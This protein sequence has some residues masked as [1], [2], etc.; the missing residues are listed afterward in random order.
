MSN[1]KHKIGFGF[2]GTVDVDGNIPETF[3]LLTENGDNII[4]ENDDT[5]ITEDG[6]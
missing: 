3:Y 1:I 6:E 2:P 4:T 5:L